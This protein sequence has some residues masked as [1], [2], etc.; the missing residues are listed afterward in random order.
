MKPEDIQRFAHAIGKLC[1]A[2]DRQADEGLIEVYRETLEDKAIV[3]IETAVSKFL[4]GGGT[5]MPRPGQLR[6]AALDAAS[7]RNGVAFVM[8]TGWISLTG[9]PERAE[10]PDALDRRADASLGPSGQGAP[11]RLTSVTPGPPRAT[12]GNDD[13]RAYAAQLVDR[14]HW[15]ETDDD[16]Q[17]VA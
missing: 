10:H 11:K 17:G 7:K 6:A 8:G 12:A 2:F 3:D 15:S 5:F 14:P 1:V 16:D 9:D 13:V 4:R